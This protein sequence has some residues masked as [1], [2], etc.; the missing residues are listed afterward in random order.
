M[1]ERDKTRVPLSVLVPV[2]N[3]AANLRDC[4]A[5]VA[6]ADEIVVVDSASTD[7]T[8]EIATAAGAR[9]VQFVWNGK[10]PRKKSWALESIPWR[11]E[12]VLIID[13]DERI[14]PELEREISLAI[15]RSD[16]DGFY[17][18]RR[19]WFL[20][21]WIN[22]CGYF[23]SWNLRLFQHRLGR[24]E[25]IEIDDDVRSGDNEVHEHVLLNGRAEYL[26]AAMEHYAFPDVASFIEK[27]NR[28]STWEAEARE[29][30]YQRAGQNTLRA[31]PFGTALE[32]KR[33]LKK[34]AMR[35]PC[36]PTLRFL[37]HYIWKQGFRDG[38]RGWVLCRL[39]AW[40][41]FVSVVKTREMS[42]R[43]NIGAMNRES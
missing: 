28:Y 27:H 8:Q 2:K 4:L 41:E 38:Y 14:T 23:P 35:A 39:L 25:R 16:A 3:E 22:H 40:Y 18:N 13:A 17:L 31:R 12:W 43:R 42:A 20:G 32:R 24:Y 26:S 1:S 5:S 7:R 11:H 30:L 29:Q 33:W 37:Y 9:V 19:F 34:L 36:R 10:F 15:R 6:F 21:G